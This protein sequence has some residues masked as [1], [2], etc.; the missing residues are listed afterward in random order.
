VAP[1]SLFIT[2]SGE[3]GRA[4]LRLQADGDGPAVAGLPRRAELVRAVG[5]RG[6]A[7][8]V[9]ARVGRAGDAEAGAAHAHALRA[10]A[11]PQ[12]LCCACPGRPREGIGVY[13]VILDKN[14]RYCSRPVKQA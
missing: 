3:R 7:E 6:V 11:Q 14:D 9:H 5:L 12:F 4:P 2:L 1:C 8:E 13:V 10:G